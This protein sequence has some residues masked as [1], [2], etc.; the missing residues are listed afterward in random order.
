M[1]FGQTL[2]TIFILLVFAIIIYCRYTHKT[3]PELIRDIK[4]IFSAATEETGGVK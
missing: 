1:T 2:L 4:E 3:L